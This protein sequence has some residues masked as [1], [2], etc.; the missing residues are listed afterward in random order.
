MS[1]A[2]EEDRLILIVNQHGENRGDESALRAMVDGLEMALGKSRYVIVVQ[3]KSRDL[4]LPFHEHVVFCNMRMP[5]LDMLGLFVF[6]ALRRLGITARF[7][8]TR[9][10]RPIIDAYERTDMVIS[11][12]GGPYFGDIYANHEIVHWF[13]VWLATVYRKK[14]FL[15]APSVGPF[16]IGWLNAVRRHLFRQFDVL[17]VREEI[18]GRYLGRLLG[19]DAEIH[20]T[21]DSA[22]Q[23]QVEPHSRADY[24]HGDRAA[25]ADRLLVAVSAIEYRFPGER[26]PEPMQRR[27]GDALM[28][29]LCHLASA[30]DCHFLLIPQLYGGAHDDTPFL[31]SIGAALP[32]DASWE[33]VDQAYDSTAQRGIFGMADLCIASRYHPQIFAACAAVPGI[34]IYYEHKA[35]GFMKALGLEDCA[36]DIR[37][38]DADAMCRRLDEIVEKREKIARQI[39][40]RMPDLRAR[41][42][43]TTELAAMLYREKHGARP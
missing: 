39:A 15:Y 24:F 5:Y 6:G 40:E 30:R 38:P 28:Q 29:C 8:L 22:I 19:K 4:V 17:C 23:Q 42:R 18:S 16:E 3:F 35:L 33:I 20:V 10:T 13:Y 25:L 36:F 11:A 32:P 2:H 14:L 21:A 9:R 37:N 12:P 1:A 31:R 34:C 7:L 27:Y 43:R 41:S 26:D